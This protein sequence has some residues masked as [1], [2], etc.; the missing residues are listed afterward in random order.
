MKQR[1]KTFLLSLLAVALIASSFFV[2]KK[3][4]SVAS[5]SYYESLK[6]APTSLNGNSI[7][8]GGET[9]NTVVAAGG[10]DA[11]AAFYSASQKASGGL[12]PSGALSI[13][14]VPYQLNWTGSSDYT[15]NDTIR[16]SRNHWRLRKTVRLRH[17]R[18][19]WRGKLRQFPCPRQLH[20]QHLRRHHL[21]SLRLVRRNSR[22]WRLQM[23]RSCSPSCG[24]I[25]WQQV[26]LHLR[27]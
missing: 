9:F 6:I 1:S 25:V 2:I 10:L 26:R 7:W 8:G 18:W 13:D 3:P 24:Q 14:G 16:Q 15:G 4:N 17:G 19:S 12:D 11:W 23:G 21:P 22:C 20:R 5:Y 27:G